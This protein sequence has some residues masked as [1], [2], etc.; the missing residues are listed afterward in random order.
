M[1]F[2]SSEEIAKSDRVD[3][4][5]ELVIAINELHRQAIDL[6]LKLD[7]ANK[8][9]Q[10]RQQLADGLPAFR[11][12]DYQHDIGS[13]RQEFLHHV[14]SDALAVGHAEHDDSLAGQLQEVANV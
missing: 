4:T 13:H 12:A 8:N 14:V 7:I 9:W 3:D 10:A 2:C 11:G 6:V 5:V 1:A